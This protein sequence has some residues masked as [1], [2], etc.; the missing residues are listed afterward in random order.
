MKNHLYR[1]INFHALLFALLCAVFARQATA[2]P[3]VYLAGD[4]T[5]MTNGSNTYPQ[6]GWGGRL[7]ALFTTGVSF[8]NRAVGGRSSK[9]FVDEG[10]LAAIL[11]VI[12]PGDY[13]FVQFGHN[14]VYSDVR[15]HTD[16]F[17]TYKTYLAMYID[18]SRQY[19]A[20]PVL[21]TPVGRRRYDSSGRFI[22]D[23]ADRSAAMKQLAAEKGVPLIDLNAK[24]IAFYNGVGVAATTD[25]FLWLAAG[26]YSN[27][28]NGVYDS[29]HF[30][31]YGATQLARLVAQ[32]I[33]ENRLGLRSY[34]GAVTYPAEAGV[35]SGTGTVRERNYSGWQGRGY[36][37]F[38][39]SGGSMTL[40]SVIGKGGG[41]RTLRIRYANGFGSARSGQLVVNGVATP[42]SFNPSGSWSTWVTKDVTVTLNGGT[43]NAIS[44]RSTGGDLANI[45]GVT[46]L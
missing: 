35:L 26:Q 8:S 27:F 13:L 42:I 34:I 25:V 6:M 43:A 46:V 4:S 12:K 22:N 24:S 19:G 39:A 36:V 9:S 29:T 40:N 10:R 30:Q 17:T 7:P 3:V 15:L 5:V 33:E 44:L 2:A 41:A 38:P 14:D 1:A 18:Q 31:D 16:P 20:I 21:V 11:G 32:G 28:P 45:D 37:N 23:F